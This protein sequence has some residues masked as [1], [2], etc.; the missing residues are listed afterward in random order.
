MSIDPI[1]QAASI[2]CDARLELA[3]FNQLPEHCRPAD[4]AMAYGVQ[5]LLHEKLLARGQGALA[6]H[7]IGC[8][9]EVMQRYLGIHNPCAGGIL[10]SALHRGEGQLRHGDFVRVGVECEIAVRLAADL[11]PG[12]SSHSRESVAAAVD[13]C[14][15]AIE[16]VDDRYVDYQRLDAPTL[17]A[18]DFF[19]A[20]AVLGPPVDDWHDL[21]LAVLEGRMRIKGET[22]GPGRGADILGHPL[23]ALAWLA[24][25]VNARGRSLHAGNIIL[26]GS[27]VQTRWLDPGDVVEVEID[28]L[29]TAKASFM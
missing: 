18:D 11:G 29:G 15:A 20:G 19:N 22:F 7:K 26:L 1:E 21:D 23:N 8:T 5:D 4:E 14:M 17:I 16:I 6:A 12:T 10:S 13:A 9:T 27:V 25:E 28:G 2:L 3:P 24:N